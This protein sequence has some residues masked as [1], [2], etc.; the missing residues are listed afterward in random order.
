MCGGGGGLQFWADQLTLFQPGGRLCPPHYYQPLK[1][2]DGVASLIWYVQWV[3]K[4]FQVSC[5]LI[6][7]NRE[8]TG[9]C[10]S[11][12]QTQNI[13]CQ[14][15]VLIHAI[16]TSNLAEA[17]LLYFCFKAIKEQAESVSGLIGPTQYQKRKR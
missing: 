6:F 17:L 3:C 8:G 15:S 11:H 5:L 10:E 14:L 2:L 13:V 7:F 12:D 4:I 16:I 9:T 1:Y